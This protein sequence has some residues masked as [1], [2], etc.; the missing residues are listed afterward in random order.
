MNRLDDDQFLKEIH[1]RLERSISDLDTSLS[2]RLDQIRQQAL[3]TPQQNI[4]IDDEP[5]VGGVVNTLED[6]EKLSPV[7]EQ[8]L[9]QIRNNA[10]TRM[11]S[12]SSRHSQSIFG[13]LKNTFA[14]RLRIGFPVPASMFASA[15]VMATVVSLFYVSSRPAGT[16]SLEEELLL[17]ASAEDIELYENLDFY[18]WLAENGLP[19]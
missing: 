11:R 17:I 1:M 8:R 5:L 4:S 7:L 6:N 15:C 13:R 2:S 10:L 16:L 12:E 18:L 19:E 14:D 9:D 3:V